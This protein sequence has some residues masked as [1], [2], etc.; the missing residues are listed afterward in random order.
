MIDWDDLRFFLAAARSRSFA[1]AGSKLAADTATV[2]RRVMRLEASL[3]TTLFKRSPAGL[4]LTSAGQS[5]LDLAEQTETS[6]NAISSVGEKDLGGVVRISAAEGF[7]TTILAPALAELAMRSPNLTVHLAAQAG[8]LSP[9]NREADIA[10]TLSAPHSS[11]VVAEP[12][13]DYALGLYASREYLSRRDPPEN[14][15]QLREHEMVGYVDDLIYAPELRYLEEILPGLR[16]RLASS[17]IIAQREI[18]NTGGGIGV[19][20]HFLASGLISV[21]G[22]EVSIRRRFWLGTHK[23]VADTTRIQTARRWLADTVKAAAR[24]LRPRAD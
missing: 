2:S 6:I 20:P 21:L 13:A 14:V 3:K 19:L 5:L 1:E 7:G 22:K 15:K 4:Q 11:R 9:G 23:E 12:L 8:F 10:I 24:R 18:I 17:S 16:P